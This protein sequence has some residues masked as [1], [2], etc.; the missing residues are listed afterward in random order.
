MASF[1]Q[2]KRTTSNLAR[3][4]V[5]HAQISNE[6]GGLVKSLDKQYVGIGDTINYT[7][8]LRNTGNT[9]ANNIIFYDTIPTGTT[10]VSNSLK[11]NGITQSGATPCPPT[12]ISIGDLAPGTASIISFQTKVD[13]DPRVNA[14][15]NTGSVSYNYTLDPANLIEERAYNSSNTVC[16]NVINAKLSNLKKTTDREFADIGD[17]ITYTTSF[18]NLGNTPLN[19]VIFKDTIPNGTVL[20]P[21]SLNI[22]GVTNTNN[23]QDGINIGTLAIGSSSTISFQVIVNTLPN[24]NPITNSSRVHYTYTVDP[25]FPNGRSEE[26]NSNTVSTCVYNANFGIASKTVDP[27]FVGLGDTVVYSIVLKNTGNVDANN[28]III[29]TVPDGLALIPDSVTIND[30]SQPGANPSNGISLGTISGGV[31]STVTFAAI[32]NKIPSSLPNMAYINYMY[33]NNPNNVDTCGTN[34]TNMVYLNDVTNA[35]STVKYQDKAYTSVGD[36]LTYT[37][38]IKNVGNYPANNIVVYDTIPNGAA[39][40]PGSI[41]INNLPALGANLSSGVSLGTILPNSSTIVT[42]KTIVDSIPSPNTLIN[43]FDTSFNYTLDP[44]MPNEIFSRNT[45]NQVVST[46]NDAII[47]KGPLGFTK[48]PDKLYSDLDDEITYTIHLKNTG[49]VPGNNTII[50]DTIPNGTTFVENSVSIDGT[51]L[52]GVNPSTGISLGTINPNNSVTLTFKVKVDTIPNPNIISN[53]ASIRYT[54]TNDPNIPNGEIATGTSNLSMVKVNHGEILPGDPTTCTGFLKS[55]DVCFA[56]RGD[57]ITYTFTIPNSGNIPVNNI[58]F[59]DTIPT[60]TSIIP[61]SVI[62]NGGLLPG[63]NPLTG[64][65]IGNINPGQFSTLSFK[66]TVDTIPPSNT[67]ENSGMVSYQYIIDPNLPPISK[68][69]MSNLVTIPVGDATVF[70]TKNVDKKFVQINDTLTY[71]LSINNTGNLEALNLL[72]TDIIPPGTE[73]IPGTVLIDGTPYPICNP[74]KGLSLAQLKPDDV[75]IIEFSAKVVCIPPQGK[76]TNKSNVTY[77]Y[78]LNPSILPIQCSSESNDVSTNVNSVFFEFIKSSMPEFA[79]VNDIVTFKF[80]I[81]NIGNIDASNIVFKDIIPEGT[82]FILDSVTVNNTSIPGICPENGIP[83]GIIKSGSTEIISFKVKIL[84]IPKVNPIP[85]S[86]SITYDSFIDPTKPPVTGCVFS[87]ISYTQVNSSCMTIYQQSNC[88]SAVIGDIITYTLTVKNCGNVDALNFILSS[89]LPPQ[90]EFQQGSVMVNAQEELMENILSGIY[91]DSVKID[92]SITVSFN[93]KV[94]DVPDDNILRNFS[95]GS[96][97]FTVDPNNPPRQG[98]LDSNI[99]DIEIGVANLSLCKTADKEVVILGDIIFYTISI[100]NVGSIRANNIV[101]KDDLPEQL[102]FVKNSLQLNYNQINSITIL[103]GINIG[104]LEPEE[105]AIISYKAKFIKTCCKFEIVNKAYAIFEFSPGSNCDEQTKCTNPVSIS[106][107]AS[108]PTFKELTQ[109]GVLVIPYPKLEIEDL[110]NLTADVEI[111]NFHVIKTLKG[112]SDEN[113]RLTGHKLIINGIVNQTLEYT[114]NDEVQS[115]HSSCFQR[116]FS[117]FIILPEDF[118]VGAHVDVK[119]VVEDVYYNQLNSREVF[120]NVTILLEAIVLC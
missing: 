39:F 78:I 41:T 104:S 101:I 81:N 25:Q 46:V 112:V 98:S 52:S 35:L 27:L 23:P 87:N 114:A 47:G 3:A 111:T 59:K 83:I 17:I 68:I 67:V 85:N 72:I 10:F 118:E 62:L 95:T 55:S 91:I 44:S 108:S 97:E 57:I 4:R 18:S 54:Y 88:D 92:N 115:V 113:R 76:I 110:N 99:T 36:I 96:Y 102:E 80:N 33:M 119:G 11:I 75:T 21:N 28:V 77:E 9:S 6:D 63:A 51:Q 12:G 105:E 49:N 48:N 43:S 24:P 22:N 64:I 34:T 116:K 58:I 65:M 19:N 93:A 45:S 79:A 2:T 16:S 90:L 86:A 42:F 53:Q 100:K 60:G 106:V 120:S 74:E 8:S 30:V 66:V 69:T 89:Q 31:V 82:E 26:L 15:N 37:L 103:C 20:V 13:N 14:I 5:N 109:D 40:V 84:E 1:N 7:I 32:T 61:N 94:I 38:G 107:R 71:S 70:I 29:D 117:S 73:F 50:Y 56:K